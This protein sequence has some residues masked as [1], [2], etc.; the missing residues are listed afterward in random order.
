MV[1]V[2]CKL[3]FWLVDKSS[4]ICP[5]TTRPGI[6]QKWLTSGK[7]FIF[8]IDA[9]MC[10]CMDVDVAMV[11]KFRKAFSRSPGVWDA[12][13]WC[14]QFFGIQ[15]PGHHQHVPNMGGD[16]ARRSALYTPRLAKQFVMP[17]I[18]INELAH[19]W[20]PWMF[21]LVEKASSWWQTKSCS[22]WPRASSSFIVFAVIQAKELW[23]RL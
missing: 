23:W 2:W 13:S 7:H 20:G 17:T 4:K 18:K 5:P 16:R 22:T 1:S 19:F 12:P 15:R 9:N 14:L 10:N 11:F 21:K 8:L 6:S 3:K